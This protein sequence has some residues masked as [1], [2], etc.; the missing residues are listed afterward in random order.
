ML[1][2]ATNFHMEINGSRG[3]LLLTS[4]IGYVGLGGFK[5]MGAQVSETLQPM[6]VPGGF[7][8][9]D[10][11]LTGNVRNLYEVFA[12]DMAHGTHHSPRFGDAVNLHRL[13]AAI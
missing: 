11:V 2:R 10:N 7:G 13:I 8:A 6:S 4:P 12:S 1:S 9:G 3:D 5:L